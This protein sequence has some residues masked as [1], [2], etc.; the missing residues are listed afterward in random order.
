MSK[1]ESDLSKLNLKIHTHE[2]KEKID[3][4]IDIYLVNSYGQTKSFYSTCKNI[5]LGG[6]IINHGGQNPL[7][8]TR[9]GCNILHGPNVSNFNEI[10]NHLKKMNIS[11]QINNEK[12]MINKLDKFFR[13]KKNYKKIQAKLRYRGLKILNSTYREIKFIIH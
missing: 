13:S 4:D 6:S 8:A 3:D 10:Y 5:F 1:I 9:Y 12:K 2:P 7:E 11:S